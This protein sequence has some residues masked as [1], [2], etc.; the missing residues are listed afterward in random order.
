MK[1]PG[2]YTDINT[3]TQ[4]T[5]LP[6]QNH[7][8][9]FVTSD[10]GAPVNPTSIYDTASADSVSGANSNAGRMIAAALSVSQG[11]RVETVGKSE[12]IVGGGSQQNTV[13]FLKLQND[14][15]VNSN[16]G[17]VGG[18]IYSVNGGEITAVSK[19]LPSSGDLNGGYFLTMYS[20][21][22][23]IPTGE[24]FLPFGR[25]GGFGWNDT[26]MPSG[27]DVDKFY[28]F[29]LNNLALQEYFAINGISQPEGVAQ[30]EVALT[31]YPASKLPSANIDYDIF[32]LIIDPTLYT[33]SELAHFAEQGITPAIKNTDGSYTIKSQLTLPLPPADV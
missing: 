15:E 25:D 31:I 29:G 21:L 26:D 17:I 5:G 4:R 23:E 14:Q 12:G 24:S 32:D 11:V 28:L 9:V 18:F 3:Q 20:F 7:S 19:P 2:I 1:T 8:I 13:S 33:P 27:L 6:T 30:G 16:D 22:P 10:V